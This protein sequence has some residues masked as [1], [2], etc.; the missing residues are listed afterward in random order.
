MVVALPLV[1]EAD[2]SV[3]EGLDPVPLF[4]VDVGAAMSVSVD[5]D[6][7]SVPVV[8]LA[9][10]MTSVVELEGTGAR[11]AVEVPETAVLV[12]PDSDPAGGA[13]PPAEA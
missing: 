2:P 13:E 11:I 1:G 7:L 9:G 10:G 6:R 3:A 8:E 5:L 12:V 4:N